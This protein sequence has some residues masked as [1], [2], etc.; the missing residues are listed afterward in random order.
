MYIYVLDFCTTKLVEIKVPEE[1]QELNTD[2]ILDKFGF[3]ENQCGFMVTEDSLDLEHL[4]AITNP[5]ILN[6]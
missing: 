5:E 2:V 1:L 4:S 6:E 3:K